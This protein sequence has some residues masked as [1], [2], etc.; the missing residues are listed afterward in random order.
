MNTAQDTW[1]KVEKVLAEQRF[2]ILAT[3]MGE[4]P[5]TGAVAFAAPEN[6]MK[7]YFATPRATRKFAN[8]KHHPHASMFISNNSN[9]AEDITR[10]IGITAV[11]T[12]AEV[13]KNRSN[14]KVFRFF[15]AR[16]PY[17]DEFINSPDTA[18]FV[19]NVEKY[20]VV[21]NFQQVFEF[22]PGDKTAGMAKIQE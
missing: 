9:L 10:A 8:L 5:Y 11:G 2:G 21:R 4:Y 7:I 12:T 14:Q 18:M 1:N 13:M 17:L 15:S 22:E 3:L 19:L 20:H 6:G 16:H